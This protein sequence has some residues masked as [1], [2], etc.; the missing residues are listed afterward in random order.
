MEKPETLTEIFS[1]PIKLQHRNGQLAPCRQPP[2]ELLQLHIEEAIASFPSGDAEFWAKYWV[3]G[4]QVLN[5]LMQ[6][7]VKYLP[8]QSIWQLILLAYLLAKHHLSTY[9]AE[10]CYSTAF[11][12]AKDFHCQGVESREL[13]GE[14]FRIAQNTLSTPEKVFRS[15]NPSHPKCMKVKTYAQLKIKTAI[16]EYLVAEGL[17]RDIDKRSDW[18]ILRGISKKQF[19]ETLKHRGIVAQIELNRF[20]LARQSFREIY[21]P[22]KPKGRLLPPSEVEWQGIFQRF[23]LLCD[24]HKL[25]R[26]VNRQEVEKLLQIFIEAARALD[27]PLG[28]KSEDYQI[29]KNRQELEQS[30]SVL[31]GVLS[32]AFE[33]LSPNCQ[34]ML[35]LWYGLQFSQKD[36]G[37]IFG[38]KQY[39]VS[40]YKDRDKQPLL[41]ALIAWVRQEVRQDCIGDE[42]I[43][44]MEKI[45]D[46]WL[47]FTCQK[48]NFEVFGNILKNLNVDDAKLLGMRYSK[49][50]LTSLKVIAKELKTSEFEVKKRLNRVQ[51]NLEDKFKEWL[52]SW[53][54]VSVNS[55]TSAQGRIHKLVASWLRDPDK[56]TFAN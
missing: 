9:L 23:N 25:P 22:K 27:S 33:G 15:Y 2:V 45:L 42:D 39:T 47:E 1:A 14:F 6:L 10:T 16:N 31:D 34:L 30:M 18:G 52:E 32:P 54:N 24:R 44:R 48:L 8:S 11:Y 49:Q 36:I 56:N 12:L 26:A 28:K 17:R 4:C 7:S 20:C 51:F 13:F 5:Y 29:D 21:T 40:R 41:N 37:I 19:V 43:Q 35:K 53:L 50:K 38:I 55:L 3:R 46:D